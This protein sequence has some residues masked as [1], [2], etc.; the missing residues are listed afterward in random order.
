MIMVELDP[1]PRMPVPAAE[2]A[3]IAKAF[4]QKEGYA[5]R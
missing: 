5:F 3:K 4:L 2:A 1:S